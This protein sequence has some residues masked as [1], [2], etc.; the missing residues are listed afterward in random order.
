[1][2]KLWLNTFNKWYDNKLTVRRKKH[3]KKLY[4]MLRNSSWEEDKHLKLLDR[5]LK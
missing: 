2:Y 3:L 5:M 4:F 1:M